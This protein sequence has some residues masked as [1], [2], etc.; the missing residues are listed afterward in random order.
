MAERLSNLGYLALSKE[1]TKGTVATT[2]SVYVP[3]FDENIA[4]DFDLTVDQSAFGNKAKTYQVLPGRR[5]YTGDVTVVGEP[6]T[7]GH[8]ANML[9]TQGSS[10]GSGP[11]TYPFT[12]S[13]STNPKSYTVDIAKGAVVHR[14]MGVE[15]ESIKIGFKDNEMQLTCKLSALGSFIVR[16]IASIS[17]T[18]VTLTSTYSDFST[19]PTT[20]LVASDL[21]SVMKADGSSQLDTTVASI[22]NGLTVVLG[23]SAAAYAAG[24]FLVLRPATAPSLTTV[25]PFLWSRSEFRFATTAASALSATHTALESGTEWE[26]MHSFNDNKGEWRSGSANPASLARTTG[27]VMFKAKQ[28]FDTANNMNAFHKNAKNAVVCRH[29]SETGYELRLTVNNFKWKNVVPK[30]KVGELFY[31]EMEAVPQ[32]D[33]SDGQMFD[34][35]VISNLSTI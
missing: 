11:Y 16:E 19:S 18:S 29:F 32:Y 34:L 5:S 35:K 1:T 6:N 2:P 10:S 9:L 7:A 28:F 8:F 23:A 31:S 25:T 15:A 30:F 3:L 12:L 17:T 22:T 4:P 14:Y 27:E 33:S 24:D 20:G 13:G 26:I 21:V